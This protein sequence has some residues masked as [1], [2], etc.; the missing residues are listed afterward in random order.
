MTARNDDELLSAW[1]DGE[2]NPTQEAA[3]RR[4][5]DDEPEL[6]VELERLRKASEAARQMFDQEL[7]ELPDFRDSREAFIRTTLTAG[8]SSASMPGASRWWQRP[9]PQVAAG[10][11]VLVSMVVVLQRANTSEDRTAAFREAAEAALRPEQ[12]ISVD[13]V[14]SR[15]LGRPRPMRGLYGP[16]GQWVF[17]AR[18]HLR[19]AGALAGRPDKKTIR[20]RH[21]GRICIGSDGGRIWLWLEGQRV[22]NVV[23]IDKPLPLLEYFRGFLDEDP[24]RDDQTPLLHWGR[25]QD[26]LEGIAKNRLGLEQAE[27]DAVGEER[28]IRYD[29]RLDDRLRSRVWIDPDD[30]AIRRVQFGLLTLTFSQPKTIPAA[31]VFHWSSRAPKGARVERLGR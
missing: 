24:R 17:E 16:G 23:P 26:I 29:V 19:V 31:D 30:K 2:L 18:G 28:L 6:E 7:E 11:L 4:R 9:W 27:E 25:V 8:P 22:V 14:R 10:T 12:F 21:D 13:V 3:V 20:I 5:L 1:L 15:L